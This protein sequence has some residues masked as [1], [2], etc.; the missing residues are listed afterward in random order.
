MMHVII[1]GIVKGPAEERHHVMTPRAP[2]G[3]LY[4]AIPLQ[5]HLPGL[6]DTEQVGLVIERAEM[7][8]AM[9][10]ALVG[11]LVAIQTIAVHHQGPR[12]DKIAGGSPRHGRFKILLALYRT[13]LVFPRVSRMQQH[14]PDHNC[15]H[16]PGPTRPYLPFDPRS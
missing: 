15:R 8:R 14:H 7:M 13:E 9:E 11:V 6:T 10:P 3:R 16:R 5:R 4:V 2:P 1:V 12:R